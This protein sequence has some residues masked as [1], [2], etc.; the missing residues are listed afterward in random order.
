[1]GLANNHQAIG[2]KVLL[3]ASGSKILQQVGDA[4][5][6]HYSQG[7]YRL[8]FGLGP[9]EKPSSVKVI[10]ADG[11]SRLITNPEADRL[12]TIEEKV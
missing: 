10:W 4:E 9:S 6:S 2:A 8:Y 1:M 11:S 3:E 12:L 5:G 7:H